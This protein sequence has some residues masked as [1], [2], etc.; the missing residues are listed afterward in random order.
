MTEGTR[1]R[2]QLNRSC[3]GLEVRLRSG[4][5]PMGGPPTRLL[6]CR[7]TRSALGAWMP[8][9]GCPSTAPSTGCARSTATNAGATNCVPKR[10]IT[11]ARPC[12]PTLRTIQ[13]C[14]S[15]CETK[16]GGR[17]GH[18]YESCSLHLT[19]FSIG[20]Q[21]VTGH[22]PF[23]PRWIVLGPSPPLE[24]SEGSR[25]ASLRPARDKRARFSVSGSDE[26]WLMHDP[27][28][29]AGSLTPFDARR[30]CRAAT[31][32]SPFRAWDL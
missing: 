16:H 21:K 20:P 13:G 25:K 28:A 10:A 5:C 8:Q 24:T 30:Y 18:E 23:T 12:T 32:T 22:P 7:G 4:S 31:G 19:Y 14:S 3:G 6:T 15:D 9:R 27:P 2:P 17:D 26:G 11:V 29:V 1:G